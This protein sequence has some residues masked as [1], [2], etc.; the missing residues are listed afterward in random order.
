MA[1]FAVTQDPDH[2]L[3]ALNDVLTVEPGERAADCLTGRAEQ[4]G[5]FLMREG[6]LKT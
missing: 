2:L 4:T 3:I 6:I 5:D 1:S